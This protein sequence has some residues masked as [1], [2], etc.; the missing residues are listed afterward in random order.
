MT[1]KKL[2]DTVLPILLA[3]G[4]GT[5]LRPITADLPKPLVPVDG[6]PVIQRILDT[7]AACGVRRAVITV[8]YRADDIEERLGTAYRGIALSYSRESHAPRGTAGGTRDAWDAFSEP[9]DTDA[10][11][12]SGDTVFTCALGAFFGFHRQKAADASLLCVPVSDPGAFGTVQTDDDGCILGFSEKPC[13][14]QALSDTVS[15]GIYCLSR[16]FTEAIPCDGAPDFGQDI[17]PDALKLGARLYAHRSDGYWCDIGTHAAYLACSL[18]ISTGQI[19]CPDTKQTHPLLPPHIFHASIGKSCEIPPTASVRKSILFDGVRIGRGTAVT[20]AIVCADVTIGCDVTV[21]GG[22]VIG[23]GCVIG[24]GVQLVRGTRLEPNTVL[25]PAAEG[26]DAFDVGSRLAPYLSDI[27]YTLAPSPHLIVSFAYALAAF[28]KKQSAAL[29]ICH[30]EPHPLLRAAE[31]LLCGTL[32]C[33]AEPDAAVFC[34]DDVLAL[35]AARMPFLPLP[36][37]TDRKSVFRIVLLR[38][39]AS[40]SAAVFDETGLYPTRDAERTLD[41]CF[42]DALAAPHSVTEP[43]ISP[44]T[45]ANVIRVPTEALLTAYLTRYGRPSDGAPAAAFSFSC[46]QTPNERLL[47]RLLETCGGTE[48]PAAPL[49]FTIPSPSEDSADILCPL[50]ASENCLPQTAAD[51][52]TVSHWQLLTLLSRRRSTDQGKNIPFPT[53]R[54]HRHKDPCPL[55]VPV[56]APQDLFSEHR[57]AHTPSLSAHASQEDDA[58]LARRYAALEAED[59]VLLARDIALMLLADGRSLPA[60]MQDPGTDG[61]E[62]IPPAH[63]RWGH[64]F[65]R[66]DQN[67]PPPPYADLSRLLHPDSFRPACEGILCRRGGGTVRIVATR[68]H[69]YRIIADAYAQ[70]AAEE[71]FRFAK[72]HLRT[73]IGQP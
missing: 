10:L 58:V 24:D 67:A 14:A 50:T 30:A 48:S 13:A 19:R 20:G 69:N 41:A 38:Y 63:R 16:A 39:G 66:A 51:A 15:T 2:P 1:A 71:L 3:G 55:S 44:F 49:R 52:V 28:A 7:L 36:D 25:P 70:E 57:Y 59:A 12:L 68:S 53:P 29:F 26:H 56:C 9:E 45:D 35:S 42:A 11:V 32:A 37:K 64:A 73:L 61:H 17:F 6:V 23:R 27:G 33:I 46:G 40:V 4:E 34:A 22:C 43:G 5:R 62:P 18:G 54:I 72:E 65:D 8:R 47:A 31:A 60:I 21:D